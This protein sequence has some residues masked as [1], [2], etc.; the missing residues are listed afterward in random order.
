MFIIFLELCSSWSNAILLKIVCFLIF[1]DWISLL[2]QF[3]PRQIAI[4]RV[5]REWEL[6]IISQYQLM[7]KAFN[8]RL[9]FNFNRKDFLSIQPSFL[10]ILNLF[11]TCKMLCSFLY[12]LNPLSPIIDPKSFSCFVI[13]WLFP[14]VYGNCLEL[15]LATRKNF[16]YQFYI[17]YKALTVAGKFDKRWC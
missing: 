14:H 8:F 6:D 16:H 4:T 9:N 7:V 5:K 10:F 15:L 17:S 3:L 13:Y 12:P 1:S 2:Q 11:R